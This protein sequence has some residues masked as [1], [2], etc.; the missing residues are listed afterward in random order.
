MTERSLIIAEAEINHNGD[1]ELAKKLVSAAKDSGAD[2]VKFQCFVADCFIAPGS[3]YL[4]IFRDVELTLDQFREIRDHA[5]TVG[6]PML[7]TAGD[8]EGLDMICQLGLDAVKIGSTNITNI[9]L[10]KA[11]AQTG[12]PAYLS[13]GASNLA[14]VDR[15]VEILSEGC[16][17]VALFH[18]TVQYPAEPVHLNLHA[19]QTLAAAF[20]GLRIGYSDHT[21]GNTAA[22]AAR[23]LGAVMFEKHF[24]LDRTLPGPDHFFSLDPAALQSYIADIRDVE[25]MLGDGR[26]VPAACEAGPRLNGRRYLTAMRAIPKGAI[27]GAEMIRPRRVEV[28]KMPRPETLLG[29]EYED[30]IVGAC[31]RRDI[32]AGET[33]ALDAF[34]YN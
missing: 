23:A 12:K 1:V 24:T 8:I 13:T 30:V 34:E 20:P 16:P 22:V 2:V 25:R 18:C 7:S 32:A 27:V 11:I 33:L 15:A 19:L 28:A 29:P 6:I 3:S 10:L 21:T 5:R 14:E 17:E 31:S 26:K 4:P 9:G